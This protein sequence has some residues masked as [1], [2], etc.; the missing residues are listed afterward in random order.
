MMIYLVQHGEA[1][2][3][4]EDPE[5]PLSDKGRAE[6]EKVAKSLKKSLKIGPSRIVHSP[7][8][9][10]KQTAE[11]LSSILNAPAEE[12]EGIK[13]LDDPNIA[14]ELVESGSNDG[15]MVVG[16]LPHL[17]KLSSLLITGDENAGIVR[18]R[19]GG[20]V[21]LEKEEKWKVKWMLTPDLV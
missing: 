14:K 18:F 9:R 17:D 11:I 13:P 12:I 16:H 1:R 4:E 21:C 2:P 20:V 7:K 19:M 10:A 15:I 6:V 8:L 5:R 3:E